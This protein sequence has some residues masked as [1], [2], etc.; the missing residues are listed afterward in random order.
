MSSDFVS[1][2]LH[3][4]LVLHLKE[5]RKLFENGS[6]AEVESPPN[7]KPFLTHFDWAGSYGDYIYYGQVI[8]PPTHQPLTPTEARFAVLARMVELAK[9]FNHD[10]CAS[11]I[12]IF[13]QNSAHSGPTLSC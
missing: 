8:V 10:A 6:L 3:K 7:E 1:S 5:T 2:L 12:V 13:I 4:R 11:S 9:Q